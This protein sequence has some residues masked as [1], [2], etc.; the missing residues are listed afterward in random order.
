[1]NKV[2]LILIIVLTSCKSINV[3]V[4]N[5]QIVTPGIPS[6]VTKIKYDTKLTIQQN[7]R[8]ESIKI[9]NRK[10]SELNFSIIDLKN[11]RLLNSNEELVKGT[12]Y[13][14]MYIPYK[15]SLE[16]S[17]ESLIFRFKTEKEK[18]IM[19]QTVLIKPLHMK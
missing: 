7:T 14:E 5:K 4:I 6:G 18:I 13:I 12:Y 10:E 17:V 3:D 2:L 9:K 8:L 11:G 15:K 1:M 19:K 16:K